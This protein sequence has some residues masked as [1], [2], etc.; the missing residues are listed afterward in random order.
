MR[1]HQMLSQII[2]LATVIPVL[3]LTSNPG[4][5]EN[6]AGTKVAPLVESAKAGA[7]K[8]LWEYP[9]DLHGRNLIYGPGGK[10]WSCRNGPFE[11]T[12]ELNRLRVMMALMNNWD[13]KD[14][15]NTVFPGKEGPVYEVSDLGA[16]FGTNG[17]LLVKQNAKGNAHSYQHSKFITK[18][19]PEYVDFATPSLP[20]LLYIFNPFRYSGR[21]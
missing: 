4:I 17:V 21:A 7:A 20:S 11:G 12:R 9:T 2:G 13:L 14:E 15:N 8:G 19:T 3:A 1:A 18:T 10:P 5:S 6:S 16:T